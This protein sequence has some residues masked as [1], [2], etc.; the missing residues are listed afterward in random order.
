[1]DQVIYQE[2]PLIIIILDNWVFDSLISADKW[3]AKSLQRFAT[4]LLVNNNLWGKWVSLSLIL[5]DDNP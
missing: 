5:F 3:F 2:K 1:M 4:C